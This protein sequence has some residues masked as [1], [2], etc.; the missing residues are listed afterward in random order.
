MKTAVLTSG[1]L[2]IACSS[3]GLFQ[4]REPENPVQASANYVPPTEPSIVFTNMQSAFRD[5]NGLNYQ[6]SFS[7]TSSGGP[8]FVFE[9]TSQALAKYGVFVSW[10]RQSELQY[11]NNFETQLTQG[12]VPSLVLSFTSQTVGSDSAL[13]EASYQLTIPHTKVNVSQSA[14]G[15]AQF[16]L[17]KDNFQNWSIWRWVDLSNQSGDFTWSDF[18]GEFGQ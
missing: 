11:F 9:P 14:I 8:S 7:D 2:L 15:H 16:Y 6:K 1:F 17:R 4:T 3:C 18:K 5:L 10:N 13:F 12:A